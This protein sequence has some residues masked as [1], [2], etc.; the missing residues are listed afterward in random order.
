MSLA[1][2]IRTHSLSLLLFSLSKQK[3]DLGDGERGDER[4]MLVVDMLQIFKNTFPEFKS[5]PFI[6]LIT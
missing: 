2:R 4:G 1:V 6:K 5:S 3:Y